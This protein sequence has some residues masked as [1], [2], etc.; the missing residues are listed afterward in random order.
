MWTTPTPCRQHGREGLR[1]EIDVTDAEWTLLE[2]SMPLRRARGQ[3]RTDLR[4]VLN[5]IFYILRGGVS[6]R[7]PPSDLLPRSKVFGRIS[8]W[9]DIGLFETINHLLVMVDRERVGREAFPSAAV[10]DGHSVK[11]TE[12]GRPRSTCRQRG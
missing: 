12:S 10:L 11:Y 6:W 8:L 4:E 5:V 9:S 2:P 1:Y 3:P 7:L